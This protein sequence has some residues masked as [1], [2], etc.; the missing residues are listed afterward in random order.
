MTFQVVKTYGHEEGW[1]CCFRQHL[2][3]HSHCRFLHGYPL[4]F[5]LTFE[6]ESLDH[7]NWVIDFG[8]L[9]GLKDWL[10]KTFDHRTLVA[11][12]DPWLNEFQ[13][14]HDLGL[15]DLFVIP[16]VGCEMFAKYVYDAATSNLK[17]LFRD[18]SDA[19]RVKLVSVKVSEHSG[20]SAIYKA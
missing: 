12:D 19:G 6:A 7:C 5:E 14:M 9:K 17:G 10:K 4:S 2:A 18:Q 1:S 16:S 3:T 13:R 11:E 15:I 8:G 20:N